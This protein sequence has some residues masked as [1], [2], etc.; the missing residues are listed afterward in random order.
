MG[1]GMGG[2]PG[3]GHGAL[4]DVVST[5]HRA[6]RQAAGN[7]MQRGQRPFPLP[8]HLLVAAQAVGRAGGAL[9]LAQLQPDG[10]ACKWMQC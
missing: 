6:G 7:S 4:A 2:R 3:G 10:V 5:Q 9:A 1:L 8:T